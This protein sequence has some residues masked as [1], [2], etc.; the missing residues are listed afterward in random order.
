MVEPTISA[1]EQ[2]RDF[3]SQ[4]AT[5][6]KTPQT[7]TQI[8]AFR[9]DLFDENPSDVLPLLRQL[10]TIR[11]WASYVNDLKRELQATW[12]AN[13]KTPKLHIVENGAKEEEEAQDPAG[14]SS[15]LTDL[16]NACRLV[17]A[18]GDNF[19]CIP[20]GKADGYLTWTGKRWEWDQTRQVER[21]AQTVPQKIGVNPRT[22]KPYAQKWYD[23]ANTTES[24][25]AQYG[26]LK[27]VRSREEV[28]IPMSR[29]DQDPYLLNMQNGTV[30]LKNGTVKPHD[31]ADLCTKL[32]TAGLRKNAECPTWFAFLKRIFQN[33]PE[34]IP[35]LQECVGYWLTGETSEQCMWIFYGGGSNGKSKFIDT[36]R[37]I[38]GDYA[39]VTS[40]STFMEKRD[41][42]IPNDLAALAGVRLACASESK[43]GAVFDE[44]MVKSCTGDATITARFLNQEFFEFMPIFKVILSTNHRPKIKGT[45]NGIWRRV[46]L[47]PFMETIKDE[48]K[49]PNLLDKLIKEADGI[50]AWALIGLE[51]WQQ[52]GHLLTPPSVMA[53]VSEYRRDMDYL[54]EFFDDR[55]SLEDK[56]AETD[57]DQLYLSYCEWAQE[58]GEDPITHRGLSLLLKERGFQQGGSRKEGRK[59]IGITL[60]QQPKKPRMFERWHHD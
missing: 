42:S 28:A 9:T 40:P 33:D 15:Q 19:K 16:G 44:G 14:Y 17:T 58:K 47:V 12:R 3:V 32:A 43:R 7:V 54:A 31:R 50:L 25:S 49:D 23:W 59:W 30:H 51:R 18:Y 1:I 22:G 6:G 35:Y 39:R 24:A 57:N 8:E 27:L 52:R 4:V 55:C 5:Q 41:G 20:G 13:G 37:H 11:G 29:L 56:R 46:R 34:M 38:M 36:I 21:W 10:A 48:E 53:A 45:D 60:I 2:L 26:M